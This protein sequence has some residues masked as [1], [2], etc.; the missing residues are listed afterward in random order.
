LARAL[1]EEHRHGKHAIVFHRC[2]AWQG[3]PASAAPACNGITAPGETKGRRKLPVPIQNNGAERQNR[4]AKIK[5]GL[6]FLFASSTI[7]WWSPAP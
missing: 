2:L 6:A 4:L 7:L 3:R 5:L 1:L